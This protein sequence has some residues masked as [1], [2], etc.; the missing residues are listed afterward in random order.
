MRQNIRAQIFVGLALAAATLVGA[1]ERPPVKT[2]QVGYRGLGMEQVTNPRDLKAKL[3]S[4]KLPDVQPKA[5]AGGKKASE[6]Y[7]NVQVLGDLTENE[8]IRVMAAVTE[9]VSPKEGCAYCH[10]L[11]N[12]AQDYPYTKIVARRMFQMTREI[13]ETWKPHVGATGVT[14]YTCHAGNPVPQNIWFKDPRTAAAPKSFAGYSAGGQNR[15]NLSVGLTSMTADPFSAL[16]ADKG[17]IRVASTEALPSKHKASI[18]SAEQTYAL[19]IHMSEGLGVN[20]T[21]C[22]NTRSFGNWSSSTPQRVTAWHGIKMVQ[23]L[24]TSYLNPLQPV[25]PKERLGKLGDAPKAFCS[26]CHQ[27]LA[28]PANGA[29]MLKDYLELSRTSL[30]PISLTVAPAPPAPP[31]KKP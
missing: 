8:F 24:N 25:Y 1:C 19:M 18:Q 10:N 15:P 22:H 28:K 20:C 17:P 7:Q 5:E 12:L 30:K 23:A 31:A 14:C 2:Q 21:Y 9:W 16:L 26:T 4:I 6:V 29:Q 13:N 3:A 11:E 27:G